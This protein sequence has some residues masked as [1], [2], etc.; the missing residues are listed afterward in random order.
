MGC[1]AEVTVTWTRTRRFKNFTASGIL[2]WK[3]P[4]KMKSPPP[5]AFSTAL[6]AEWHRD[7][8][9]QWRHRHGNSGTAS[10]TVALAVP[11]ALAA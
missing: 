6:P 10:G 9:C 5:A 3:L 7:R 2:T 1:S 4:V 11:L 8:D